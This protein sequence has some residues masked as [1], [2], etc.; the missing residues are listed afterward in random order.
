M[1]QSQILDLFYE[2]T[3]WKEECL[4]WTAAKDSGGYGCLTVKGK[5]WRAHRFIYS[6]L[7]NGID[8]KLTIDHLCRNRSCV[9]IQHLEQVSVGENV[10][11]GISSPA[12]NARKTQCIHDHEFTP[13]N[14]YIRPDG[15]RMCKACAAASSRRIRKTTAWKEY[16][17]EYDKT[18]QRIAYR[19][20]RRRR[21]K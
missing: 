4:I 5:H 10:L 11:R 2:K 17:K 14:T 9:N 12:Q 16:R 3:E 19:K 1:T 13:E 20:M 6:I 18:S 21:M 8:S 7:K 15:K